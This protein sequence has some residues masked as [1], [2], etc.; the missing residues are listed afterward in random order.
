MGFNSG[1]KGLI[2][3]VCFHSE[4]VKKDE[5]RKHF[6]RNVHIP[7]CY[8]ICIY[9]KSHLLAVKTQIKMVMGLCIMFRITFI[10][11]TKVL[12]PEAMYLLHGAESSWR[13]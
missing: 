12:I 9:F 8:V 1:F 7:F 3:V 11:H 10:L 2:K 13:N 6:L 5:N 4:I